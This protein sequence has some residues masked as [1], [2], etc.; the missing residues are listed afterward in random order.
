MKGRWWQW[1]WS[2]LAGILCLALATAAS[3]QVVVTVSGNTAFATIS[4]TG[5]NGVTYDADVTIVFDTPQHLTARNLNLTAEVI[6]PVEMD[7]R[8]AGQNGAN[9]IL[10]VCPLVD[11]DFPVLVTVEPLDVPMMY[12]ISPMKGQGHPVDFSFLN[13]YQFDVHTHDLVYEQGSLYR[14]FKAPVDGYFHDV[15]NDVLPGSV[16]VRGRGGAFSQ[17]VV[18]SDPRY[19]LLTGPLLVTT[20]KLL[21]LNARILAAAL[22]DGLRLDLLNLLAQ[23][24]ALLVVDLVGAIS[25]LDELIGVIDE[26]AGTN[27]ANV[28]TAERNLINDAGEMDE[29]AD[30]LRF[31]MTRMLGGTANP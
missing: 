7:A 2:A 23:V 31:S 29:L 25:T 10:G 9:C 27:I 19:T 14:L 20:Q 17:F 26:N 12:A 18:A 5:G 15:T 1:S 8:L 6:D 24:D 16:R 13:T 4:L 21:A 22:S 11:P 28:W 30:T 3:A